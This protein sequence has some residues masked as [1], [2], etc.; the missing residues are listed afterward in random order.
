MDKPVDDAEQMLPA[1]LEAPREWRAT[2][3]GRRGVQVLSIEQ[4]VER[5]TGSEMG[6]NS[7]LGSGGVCVSEKVSKLDK[8]R[9]RTRTYVSSIMTVPIS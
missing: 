5:T 1:R 4:G 3:A 6:D 7:G 8:S 9:I 2:R